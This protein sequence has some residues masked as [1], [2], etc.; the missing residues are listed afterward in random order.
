MSKFAG[1]VKVRERGPE[2]RILVP[3]FRVSDP[4]AEGPETIEGYAARFNTPSSDLGG[5]I[6]VVEPGAFERSIAE[7][8]VRAMQNHDANRV[9]GRNT[10]GTLELAEDETGLG[11]RIV[12]PAVT[13]A[14]DL[15]VS[16]RRG[17]V[18]QCSFGFTT[19][20]DR[21]ETVA[22]Q[23]YRYLIDVDLF[24]VSV[25]TFPAY[26]ETLAEVRARALEVGAESSRGAGS[27]PG[28]T[29]S[30]RRGRR[31]IAVARLGLAQRRAR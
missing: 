22:G 9:L 16:M 31:S 24:D 29:E 21:W 28:E 20:R 14:R 19:I 13:W 2:R 11:F 10:A 3:E 12:V 8:D 5:F 6:E 27:D 18:D 15:L 26:P 17:D 30:E 25:V 7:A 4:E 1:N 23:V